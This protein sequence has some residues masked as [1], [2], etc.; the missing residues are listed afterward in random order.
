MR[1][2]VI[3]AFCVAPENV[4]YHPDEAVYNFGKV[5]RRALF[6]AISIAFFAQRRK[7]AISAQIKASYAAR[8]WRDSF[9]SFCVGVMF[10]GATILLCVVLG[11]RKPVASPVS[12]SSVMKI[13]VLSLAGGICASLLEETVFRAY[14]F[15]SLAKTRGV[16]FGA[17]VSSVVFSAAHFLRFSMYIPCRTGAVDLAVGARWIAGFFDRA[18]DASGARLFIGLMIVGML[19]AYL[20]GR[21]S[22]YASVGL[23]AGWVAAMKMR[24]VWKTKVAVSSWLWGGDAI[25][26]GVAGW[27]LLALSGAA[28]WWALGRVEKTRKRGSAGMMVIEE[29]PV[30]VEEC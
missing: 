30:S 10:V 5:A 27:T 24:D 6:L 22:I 15:Q 23:H 16:L 17:V 18:P 28:V 29:K 8:R 1:G 11:I 3:A 2:S 19:L 25:I 12:F 26:D 20:C 21:Y 7:R 13:V 4:A 14:L 9:V